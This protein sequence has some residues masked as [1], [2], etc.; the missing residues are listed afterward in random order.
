MQDDNNKNT[1]HNEDQNH[2]IGRKIDENFYPEYT[3]QSPEQAPVQQNAAAEADD[4]IPVIDDSQYAA[5]SGPY[6][7]ANRAMDDADQP[8]PDADQPYY[9]PP[10][11]TSQPAADGAPFWEQNSTGQSTKRDKPKSRL[12]KGG[13]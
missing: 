6:S 13:A 3:A 9:A 8:Q 5:Q 1:M 2:D 12:T 7:Y 10:V 4:G 11:Y